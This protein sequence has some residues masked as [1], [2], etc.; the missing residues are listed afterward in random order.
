MQ[1]HT[2]LKWWL[3]MEQ[4]EQL[5]VLLKHLVQWMVLHLLL[6]LF[7]GLLLLAIHHLGSMKEPA[8]MQKVDTLLLV[9]LHILWLLPLEL[10]P[11]PSLQLLLPMSA[12]LLLLAIPGLWEE[13][14]VLGQ[15]VLQLS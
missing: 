4:E 1:E 14:L 8:P 13:M 7:L 12:K 5:L 3:K 11:A 2:I 15:Q 10:L 6:V 9:I